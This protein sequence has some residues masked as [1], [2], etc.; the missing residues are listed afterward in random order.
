VEQATAESIRVRSGVLSPNE[1]MQSIGREDIEGGDQLLVQMQ[2]IPL[3]Q[4]QRQ[5]ANDDSSNSIEQHVDEFDEV[6][7]Q[8]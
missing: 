7:R 1:V 6:K 2:M 8:L 3:D 4:L 5:V